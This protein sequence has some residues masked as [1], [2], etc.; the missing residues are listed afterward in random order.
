MQGIKG[1]TWL[2]CLTRLDLVRGISPKYMHSGLL[3]VS[4]H[5][6]NL[7][8]STSRCSGTAD[9]LHSPVGVID[10]RIK[11][12]KVPNEL[13]WRPHDINELAHWKGNL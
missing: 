6:L 13:Q 12:I 7:W 8:T 4:K 1:E 9:D 3:G 5:L 10:D 2:S 11:T